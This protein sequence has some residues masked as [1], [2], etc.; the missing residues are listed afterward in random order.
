[1]PFSLFESCMLA[2]VLTSGIGISNVI[3]FFFKKKKGKCVWPS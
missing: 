3:G 2:T 1:M